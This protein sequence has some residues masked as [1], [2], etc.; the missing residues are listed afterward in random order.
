MF[1]AIGAAGLATAGF[2]AI[3]FS[4]S[5]SEESESSDEESL[6]VGFEAVFLTGNLTGDFFFVGLASSASDDS[7]S[8]SSLLL[9]S[10][11]FVAGF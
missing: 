1:S 2:L 8:E 4:S 6:L 9:L 3:C 5:S 10:L 11:P 7:S